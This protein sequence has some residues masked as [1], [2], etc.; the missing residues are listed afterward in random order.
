MWYL[1]NLR[2]TQRVHFENMKPTANPDVLSDVQVD[3]F[4]A[5]KPF[6]LSSVP[7]AKRKPFYVAKVIALREDAV[8]VQT[9]ATGTRGLAV[10][11]TSTCVK[12]KRFQGQSP[13]QDV[14]AEDIITVCE[15]TPRNAL[16]TRSKKKIRTLLD[17]VALKEAHT[18][19][20]TVR[21]AELRKRSAALSKTL[22]APDLKEELTAAASD[23]ETPAATTV[24]P[25]AAVS[26]TRRLTRKERKT[27][28]KVSPTQFP[29]TKEP[30][31]KSKRKTCDASSKVKKEALAAAT[32]EPATEASVEEEEV[33]WY[34]LYHRT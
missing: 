18:K 5:Y 4:I 23:L 27:E 2:W 20:K 28:E 12:Y 15:L 33:P 7:Q 11:D 25:T 10:L 29:V 21:A 26:V 9:Y 30:T 1:K 6:Y 32:V 31:P 24:K 8:Q 34:I 13:V 14:V 22:A 16:R 19:I 17:A 3:D